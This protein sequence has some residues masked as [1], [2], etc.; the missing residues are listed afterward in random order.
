VIG[1]AKTGPVVGRFVLTLLLLKFWDALENDTWLA[2]DTLTLVK[3]DNAR[4]AKG[5]PSFL[6]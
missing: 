2:V 3:C 5:I 1:N 4:E 6:G